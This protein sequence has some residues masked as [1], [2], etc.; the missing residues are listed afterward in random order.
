[1]G[2]RCFRRERKGRKI[3]RVD[4]FFTSKTRS[5]VMI[6]LA[7]ALVHYLGGRDMEC[8]LTRNVGGDAVQGYEFRGNVVQ[9]RRAM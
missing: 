8:D 5:L 1:M 7:G 2:S 6:L 4:R 3:G 9:R